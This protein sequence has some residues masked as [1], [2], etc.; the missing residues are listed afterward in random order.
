MDIKQVISRVRDK[1]VQNKMFMGLGPYPQNVQ[2]KYQL[3]SDDFDYIVDNLNENILRDFTVVRQI[4]EIY[5]YVRNSAFLDRYMFI[6]TNPHDEDDYSAFL[7]GSQREIIRLTWKLM[8]N[9]V[10]ITSNFPDT[11]KNEYMNILEQ[12]LKR[13]RFL[14]DF[15]VSNENKKKDKQRYGDFETMIREFIDV[16]RT[17][18]HMMNS[19]FR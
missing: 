9:F 12:R 16:I 8:M 18:Q 11:L 3:S 17:E 2:I 13:I 4:N 7:D 1:C 6:Y 5:S 19:N 10:N 14:Y 15:V